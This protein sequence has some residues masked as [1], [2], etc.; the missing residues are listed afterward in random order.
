M[1]IKDTSLISVYFLAR[2]CVAYKGYQISVYFLATSVCGYKVYQ[3]SVYF[4]ATAVC[5]SSLR[6]PGLDF[7]KPRL[8]I[9]KKR[10]RTRME[11][12]LC[13]ILIIN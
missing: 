6:K 12:F 8:E 2:R 11:M 3:F 4:L 7:C 5:G 13:K 1:A 10:I 9:E